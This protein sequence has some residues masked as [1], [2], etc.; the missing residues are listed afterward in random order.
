[1]FYNQKFSNIA[2]TASQE[3][4]H[5]SSGGF[6]H[7]VTIITAEAIGVFDILGK[8]HVDG[9]YETLSESIDLNLGKTIAFNGYFVNIKVTPQ[10]SIDD[11]Y[12]VVFQGGGS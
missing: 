8:T 6:N 3:S 10:A 11:P 2:N 1:M 9:A 5:L 12:S 4:D 7:Q